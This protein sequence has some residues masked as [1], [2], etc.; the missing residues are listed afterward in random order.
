M[1]KG[2]R[3]RAPRGPLVLS[4]VSAAQAHALST[5][6]SGHTLGFVPTMGALHDGHLALLR[7]ARQRADTVV[8]S[9]FV[10]PLQ[11]DSD[12]D[13]DAYPE[14]LE[15]DVEHCRRA[16]VDVVFAPARAQIYP[17]GFQTQ[18]C[19]G[20]LARPFE[21]RS[22]PGHFDGMLTVVLKL[23]QIVQPH[24]AVFGEKD[25]QQLLLVRRMVQDFHLPIEIVP[26]PVIRET[27]G[28]ALSSRNQ[29]LTKTA[30]KAGLALS[31]AL[32]ATQDRVAAGE[33]SVKRLL[34]EAKAA[35]AR[36]KGLD[37][38]YCAIV[39]PRSLE[40][41]FS[42]RGPAR[43]LL[44]GQVGG[45]DKVRLIDNGPLFPPVPL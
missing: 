34:D 22:R 31:G 45:K 25:Y 44:A 33:T 36:T 20:T 17:A 30:R 19:A 3:A 12:A 11:F 21:G 42:V 2:Q 5:R 40:R 24:F 29:R 10:N 9:I 38:D 16:G 15:Q 27:D 28:L 18:V 4:S 8:V 35:L 1:S 39:D 41:V 7:E 32:I 14:T 13:L 26:M 6:Q 43:M 23:F 37:L